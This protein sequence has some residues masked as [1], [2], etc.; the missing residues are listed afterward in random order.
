MNIDLILET[1]NRHNVRYLLIGG[2][3]FLLRHAPILT[4]DVDLWIEDTDSNCLR[5]EAALADLVAEWGPTEETWGFT[6]TLPPGWLSRQSI[7]CMSSSA[8][9]IDVFRYV[10]GLDNWQSS[11]DNSVIEQTASGVSYHGLSDSDMLLCQYALDPP[12]QKAHRIAAL[13]SALN[14]PES[15]P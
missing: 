14:I 4:Y 12:Y 8:G 2:V 11:F 6:S 1:F 9:A 15:L 10:A 5:C 13:K 7:C 3:N